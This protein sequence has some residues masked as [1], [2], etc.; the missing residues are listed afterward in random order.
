[1]PFVK[2][3]VQ[4]LQG[5]GVPVILFARGS[6]GHRRELEALDCAL[7]IDWADDLAWWAHQTTHVLQG[8][9]DPQLLVVAPAALQPHLEQLELWAT[10]RGGII[11]NLGHGLLPQTP[12]EHVKSLTERVREG[13]WSSC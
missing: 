12:F 10:T 11:C 6:A 2:Q 5:L 7:S 13:A 3:L 9:L 4:R 8:N 1:M